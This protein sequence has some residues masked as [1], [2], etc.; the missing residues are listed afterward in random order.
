MWI[1]EEKGKNRKCEMVDFNYDDQCNSSS[2]D[3]EEEN[4]LEKVFKCAKNEVAR[5]VSCLWSQYVAS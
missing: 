2:Q 4:G 1:E 3:E 5:V